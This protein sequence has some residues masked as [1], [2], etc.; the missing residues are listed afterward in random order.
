VKLQLHSNL[1]LKPLAPVLKMGVFGSKI[2]DMSLSKAFGAFPTGI[3]QEKAMELWKR[4]DEN[5]DGTLDKEEAKHMVIDL[6]ELTVDWAKSNIATILA[7]ATEGPECDAQALVAE[8]EHNIELAYKMMKDEKVIQQILTDFDTDG[9]GQISK[10]EFLAK[11]TEGYDL[12]RPVKKARTM[13]V[14][15]HETVDVNGTK[16]VV[17]KELVGPNVYVSI[18]GYFG[19]ASPPFCLATIAPH[20]LVS[21]SGQIGA[22]P[23]KAPVAVSGGVGPE[24]KQCLENIKLILKA[25]GLSTANLLKVN[26]YLK[27]NDGDGKPGGRFYQMNQ[28]YTTFFGNTPHHHLPARITVGCGGLAGNAQVEIDVT[29]SV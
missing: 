23:G 9:D 7:E 5:D 24:T 10:E 11:A 8:N 13:A 29:A 22:V 20:G 14:R 28:A 4:Y 19:G 17:R 12:L 16:M 1:V 6:A 18:D 26:V 27:D 25:C 15:I 2:Q 21:V 3:S